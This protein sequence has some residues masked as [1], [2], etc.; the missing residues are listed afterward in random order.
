MDEWFDDE[1]K[2]QK[3]CSELQGMF[4]WLVSRNG[5]EEERAVCWVETVE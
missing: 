3:R 2:A 5:K 4:D 1:E